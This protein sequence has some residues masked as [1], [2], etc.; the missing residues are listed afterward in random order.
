[1][2]DTC[3]NISLPAGDHP[4]YLT[5]AKGLL[6][7]RWDPGLCCKRDGTWDS[8]VKE[9]GPGGGHKKRYM[10]LAKHLS[11]AQSFM[12][13]SKLDKSTSSSQKEADSYAQRRGHSEHGGPLVP[14]PAQLP[15]SS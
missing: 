3:K 11:W 13:T 15:G 8:A 12:D 7:K 5:V 6:Q 10:A 2:Q 9:M 4:C 14:Q 1:M